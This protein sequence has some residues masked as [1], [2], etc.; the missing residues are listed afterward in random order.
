[1]GAACVS[2]RVLQPDEQLRIKSLTAKSVR[3]GPGVVVVGFGK[4][5]SKTKAMRLGPT[6]YLVVEDELSGDLRLVKGPR[7]FFPGA[8]DSIKGRRTAVTLAQ[9]E[10]VKLQN[11]QTGAIRVERGE[12]IVYVEPLEEFVKPTSRAQPSRGNV[13][14]AFEIDLETA[15][16]VRN[17]ETGE[18]RLVSTPQLFY[19][20][21][22]EQILEERKLI[23]L[24]DYETIIL[25]SNQGEFTFIHGSA[26]AAQAGEVTSTTAADGT[27]DDVVDAAVPAGSATT[28]PMARP[29]HPPAGAGVGAGVGAGADL[30]LGKPGSDDESK[31]APEHKRAF[32]VPPYSSV[33]SLN[34]STG[35]DK[36]SNSLRVKRID[37]RPQF[38]NYS[39]LCR[40]SDNVEL[41][42][43]VTFFWE[44]VNVPLMLKF[45]SDPPG[46]VCHHARS[47]VINQ[48]TKVTL[49]DFMKNFQTIVD[50]AI[51]G[52]GVSFYEE[53]G[54][55][56]HTVEVLHFHCKDPAIE[57]VLQQIIQ[58]STNRL[59]RLQQQESENEVAVHR[60]RGDI[61]EERLR[62]DL[63]DIRHAHHRSEAL[64]EGEAEADRC[65]AFIKGLSEIVSTEEAVQLFNT[66]RKVEVMGRLANGPAHMYFTPADCDLKIETA[67]TEGAPGVA[68]ANPAGGRPRRGN[69]R[70]GAAAGAGAGAG[71]VVPSH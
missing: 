28:V 46:D 45:T 20:G 21:K 54:V 19:C 4:T 3:N 23:R 61:D 38:M 43:T 1:M 2:C 33:V 39:F 36:T 55:K 66:M 27:G 13:W 32:F 41:A 18:Q 24:L 65:K 71:A 12:K 31:A 60:I 52:R 67:V 37:R 9:N 69:S 56:I 8:Y 50:R 10:Y 26:D 6:E 62:G 25:V 57:K 42:L 70:A 49:E 44:I 5:G 59:N 40:T 17:S 63:L 14:L 15:A 7:L 34:W 11:T 48:V 29:P 47:A 53:R 64:M 58:E 68:R 30:G 35:G 22:Y 51:F 16:L